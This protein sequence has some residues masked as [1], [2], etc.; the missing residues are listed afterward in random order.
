[1][2]WFEAL[3]C[4]CDRISIS[5]DA[6]DGQMR[7]AREQFETVSGKTKSPVNDDGVFATLDGWSE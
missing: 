2:E 3:G 1:M 6:D 5:I 7:E 4:M